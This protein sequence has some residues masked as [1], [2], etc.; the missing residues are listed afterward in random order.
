MENTSKEY[1]DR[2]EEIYQKIYRR[3]LSEKLYLVEKDTVKI[4]ESLKLGI[5]EEEIIKN[6]LKTGMTGEEFVENVLLMDDI[7]QEF[8]EREWLQKKARKLSKR[9]YKEALKKGYPIDLNP[10][11]LIEA[12]RMEI[13]EEE[14]IKS[15]LCV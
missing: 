1:W 13:P 3:E 14:I 15:F 2:A 8:V 5:S 9:I 11:E 4:V 12:L 6:A 7:E 10:I